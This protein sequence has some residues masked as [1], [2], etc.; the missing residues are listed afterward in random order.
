MTATP[1]APTIIAGCDYHFAKPFDLFE[2]VDKLKD[3]FQ[4]KPEVA[5]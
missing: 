1:L 5:A 4:A 3:I 2:L